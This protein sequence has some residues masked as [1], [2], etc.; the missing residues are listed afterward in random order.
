MLG[1]YEKTIYILCAVIYV[2]FG[3]IITNY[4]TN[5][6]AERELSLFTDKAIEL[7]VLV[8][9]NY[10][11]TDAEI[12]EIKRLEFKDLLQ[13]QANKRLA[14]LFGHDFK[15]GDIKYAYIMVKLD[16][17]QIKYYITDEYKEFYGAETGTPLNLLWLVDFVVHQTPE[18]LLAEDETYYDDI[19]RYSFFRDESEKA[20]QARIP[21]YSVTDYEYG[22]LICGWAP[23]YSVE[24]TYAGMLGVDLFIEQYEDAVNR[25]KFILSSVFTIPTVLLTVVFLTLYIRSKKQIYSK[26][27]TDSLTSIKNRRFIDEYFP[28]MVKEHYKKKLPLSV[29]MIDVDCFKLYND[30]YG[31][32]QGDE[33]LKNIS[34]AIQSVLRERT[35]YICRYGGEEIFVILTN[36]N[37]SGAEIVASRINKS[38]DA[39]AMKHEYSV[40][41]PIV[42]VSQGIYSAVP[43]NSNSAKSFIKCADQGLY[44]AKHGGR[45]QFIAI[46]E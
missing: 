34:K 43:K 31:H 6:M 46:K 13:H 5:V 36:T 27:Y 21:V 3:V 15:F 39:L 19:K 32:Q 20:Y 8:S 41:S 17:T 11:I 24:G 40:C 22:R 30:N 10:Q 12:D 1:K 14:E 44:E 38:V 35:D 29:I 4:A 7:A 2:I 37:L 25:I 16:E 9:K 18:E 33:A 26:A 45:H 28:S 42:T 23:F